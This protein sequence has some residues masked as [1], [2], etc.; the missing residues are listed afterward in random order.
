MLSALRGGK[1]Q[2]FAALATFAFVSGIM[3]MVLLGTGRARRGL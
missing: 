2:L 3:G 1:L